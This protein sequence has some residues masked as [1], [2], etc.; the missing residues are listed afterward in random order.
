MAIVGFAAGLVVL[1]AVRA[2]TIGSNV[3]RRQ[4]SGFPAGLVGATGA[5][6]SPS[7]GSCSGGGAAGSVATSP[8]MTPPRVA[9]GR[10]GVIMRQQPRVGLTTRAAAG[11]SA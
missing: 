5:S 3:A 4:S 6:T 7:T 10:K 2:V 9:N 8:R 11:F 1:F